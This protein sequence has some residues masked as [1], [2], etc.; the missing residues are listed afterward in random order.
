MFVL[1]VID[2]ANLEQDTNMGSGGGKKK[3][4]EGGYP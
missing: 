3:T 1:R 4:G 2:L